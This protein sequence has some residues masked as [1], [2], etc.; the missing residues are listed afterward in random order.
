MAK[1]CQ[2]PPFKRDL[3]AMKLWVKIFIGLIL[4]VLTGV[5]LGENAVYLKPLGTIFLNLINMIIVLLIFASMAVGIN[6][7][8]DPKKLGRVGG[9]TLVIYFITTMIAISSALLMANFFDL[10]NGLNIQLPSVETVVAPPTIGEILISVVPSNPISAMASGNILQVIVFAIF[11]GLAINFSGEK[12]QPLLTVLDSLADVMYRL[13]SIIMEFSPIGVFGIMAWVS[14]TFG[15]A[16]LLP[17]IKF[18]A[19][20]Y[21]VCF[22]QIG[23]VYYNLVRMWAGLPFGQFFKGMGDAFMIAFTTCS[24]AAALPA[25]LHCAQDNLGISKNISSFI[26]PLGLTFN[27]NGTAIFQSMSAVF[28]A[29]A[30]GIELDGSSYLKLSMTAILSAIGTAGAGGGFIMLSAV[31]TSIGVPLEGLAIMVGIDRLRE[32]MSTFLNILGDSAVTVYI[33]KKEGE[34]NEDVYY[35]NEIVKFEPT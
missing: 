13:T 17:L 27:M 9:K 2:Y 26:M 19:V 24:S 6:K 21:L 20:Y 25:A 3:L 35:H 10:G 7:I 15:L 23:V 4:G 30:Y 34:L 16:L 11:L 12:G 32:M 33:A 14:G 18:L 28:L 1:I 22:L 8:H 5:I 31:L 29:H